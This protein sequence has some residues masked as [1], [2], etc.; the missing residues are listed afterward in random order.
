MLAF[1]RYELGIDNAAG[2]ELAKLLDDDRGRGYG[3][4]SDH[5]RIRLA[6]RL[7]YRESSVQAVRRAHDK[8]VGLGRSAGDSC[9]YRPPSSV[10][11][12]C[13]VNSAIMSMHLAGHSTAQMPHPLQ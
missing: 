2:S 10:D 1:D 12:A 5:V 3:I 7:R 9:H 6:H 4:A 8:P 13:K 11:A